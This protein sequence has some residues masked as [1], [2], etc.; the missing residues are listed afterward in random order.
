M[1]SRKKVEAEQSLGIF[2]MLA[3]LAYFNITEVYH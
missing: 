1:Q 2:G 3:I